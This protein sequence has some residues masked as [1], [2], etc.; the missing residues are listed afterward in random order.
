MVDC[1][2][3]LDG[4]PAM[5]IRRVVPDIKS[6]RID[7]SRDFYAGFLGFQVDD[8]LAGRVEA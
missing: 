1:A 4:Q 7:E 6:D 3:A 2:K 8:E 5:N